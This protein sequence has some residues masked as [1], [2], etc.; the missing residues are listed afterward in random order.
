V[1]PDREAKS[2]SHEQTFEVDVADREEV[3]RVLLD[4]VEQ[5]ARRLRKHGLQAR[6]VALKIR[7][8]DFQTISRSTTLATPTDG[9]SELWQA[10]RGLFEKW[11]FRPVRLIGMGAERLSEGETQ[12]PLFA[13]PQRDR[14]RTLDAVADRIN[15]KFGNR[16]IRR[17][18]GM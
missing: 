16:M 10:A 18:G 14:Q 2:I 5:V 1:V 17:G 4:Q 8:G 15:A 3:L 12:M 13:D 6:G 9:T 11:K 7:Y